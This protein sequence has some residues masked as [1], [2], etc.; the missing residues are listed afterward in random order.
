MNKLTQFKQGDMYF[1][2]AT[3]YMNDLK[4]CTFNTDWFGAPVQGT[5][6]NYNFPFP[7]N[8][9]SVLTTIYNNYMVPPP[10]EKRIRAHEIS[11]IREIEGEQK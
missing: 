9:D 5:F 6:E 7:S 2:F 11:N 8:A 1:C 10:P 3:V 4:K